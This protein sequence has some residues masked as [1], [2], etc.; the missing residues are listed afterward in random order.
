[1]AEYEG[2]QRRDTTVAICQAKNPETVLETVLLGKTG[3]NWVYSVEF[4]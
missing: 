1:M 3:K 2:S 4:V